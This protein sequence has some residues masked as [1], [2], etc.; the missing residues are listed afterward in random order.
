[1]KSID[2]Q[3][4]S[5]NESDTHYIYNSFFSETLKYTACILFSHMNVFCEG[6]QRA[7]Y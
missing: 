3:I 5:K 6:E 1:M 4:I 7:K 2:Y